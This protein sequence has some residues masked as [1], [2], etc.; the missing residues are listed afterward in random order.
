MAKYLEQTEF[1]GAQSKLKCDLYQDRESEGLLQCPKVVTRASCPAVLVFY[2]WF[3]VGLFAFFNGKQI[4]ESST[5]TIVLHTFTGFFRAVSAL[6]TVSI[7][8]HVQS[9]ELTETECQDE[10]YT[11]F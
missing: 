9:V 3:G 10:H 2:G 5:T 1:S 11:V 6:C 8:F 7:Y 4:E